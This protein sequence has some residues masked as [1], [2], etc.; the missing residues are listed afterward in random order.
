MHLEQQAGLP[1]EPMRR[2]SALCGAEPI[3]TLRLSKAQVTR[4]AAIRDGA[5]GGQGA[6]ELGYRLGAE[7]ARDAL[8]LR[9]A[10]MEHPL[11]SEDL[12]RAEA[13]AAADFPISAQ[14]L[15]PAHSGATLGKT[16]KSLEQ[17]W[18]DSGFTLTKPEL[19]DISSTLKG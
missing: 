11:G 9:A 13:G 7:T 16:L 6:G 18:I 8:V 5:T 10:L 19:L 2:L 1:P 12:R 15:M 4:A 17:S 3:G 14:D